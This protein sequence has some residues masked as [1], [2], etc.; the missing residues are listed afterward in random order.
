MS[1]HWLSHTELGCIRI[2]ERGKCIGSVHIGEATLADDVFHEDRMTLEFMAQIAR[3][4][5]HEHTTFVITGTMVNQLALRT[6]TS[7][8]RRRVAWPISNVQAVR[9]GSGRYPTV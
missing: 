1:K 4:C 6:H 7:S 9:P 2:T 3:L 5:G 8:T